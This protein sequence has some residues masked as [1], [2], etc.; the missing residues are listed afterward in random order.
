MMAWWK[1]VQ[2][3]LPLQEPTYTRV[4]YVLD[5]HVYRLWLMVHVCL[6]VYNWVFLCFKWSDWLYV[7]SVSA[8][9]FHSSPTF[10]V[11]GLKGSCCFTGVHK[12]QLPEWPT[13]TQGAPPP[14]WQYSF[15]HP[16]PSTSVTA[17]VRSHSSWEE[18][19]EN[20]ESQGEER[21][22][23]RLSV[24]LDQRTLQISKG[25]DTQIRTDSRSHSSLP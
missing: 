23:D 9:R 14:E 17:H 1:K 8:L 5:E 21:S 24:T 18:H 7:K 20:R 11:I 4:L 10:C 22:T 25:L 3:P 16:G 12:H 6:C 13:G 2:T 19:S 15:S